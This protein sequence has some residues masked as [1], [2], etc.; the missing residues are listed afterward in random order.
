MKVLV[1]GASGMLGHRVVR[2]LKKFDL[3]VPSRDAYQ[4]GQPLTRF[5]LSE[6]DWV[7]N[8]IGAIPQKGHNLETMIKINH[9]FPHM[10][11][12]ETS[13]KVI[14]IATDCAF[15]GDKGNYDESSTKDAIDSYG[16]TKIAGEVESFMQLRCS[17]I[18]P[19]LTGKKSL[20]EW[21]RNQPYG[22]D[23]MGYVNH[24]WNGVTT[25]AFAQVVEGVIQNDLF[26]MGTHHLIPKDSVS[27]YQLIK[28]IAKKL[29][30][31]DLKIMPK[32]TEKVDRTLTT[33]HQRLNE[34]LWVNAGYEAPPTIKKM[35]T[36][37]AIE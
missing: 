9:H 28:M 37:L 8:C 4:A 17:I 14:Q 30:R 10:I 26:F 11:A 7:V 2:Q 20:F 23:M 31:P 36:N 6:N 25:D 35:I 16:L 12:A 24:Y 32:I 3:I 29:D 15:L 34:L 1:L 27:K 19:E 21:V 33:K 5:G 22:E 13:A 18:G